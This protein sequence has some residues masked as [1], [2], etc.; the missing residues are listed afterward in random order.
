MIGA[1]PMIVA[2]RGASHDAPENTLAAF[3]LAWQQGADAIEGDF[4][5]TADGRIACLHDAATKRTAGTN[6]AVARST[7]AEL[8]RLDVGA[9]KGASWAGERIPTLEEVL[10]V[11]PQGKQIFIEIK[12]GPEIVPA[13]KRVLAE[14]GLASGQ[15]VVIAFDAEV[16]AAVKQQLP[17]LRAYW[18]TSYKQAPKNGPWKPTLDEVLRTLRR[19][20]ADGLDSQA[21]DV[22]DT[23]F[24]R[25]LAAAGF[26][27]HV[28]T[29]DDPKVAARFARLGAVSITTNRP[30][31]LRAQLR[32][33]LARSR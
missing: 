11:V 30:E 1:E 25:S 8:R 29:V 32:E 33:E 4:H 20:G 27:L 5:L 22:I 21:H 2:H 19:I 15:T 10:A 7:L 28:W 17:A 13:L 6:L 18:L 23:P 24:A 3:R 9:W 14:A 12:C 16:I 31:W 26:P